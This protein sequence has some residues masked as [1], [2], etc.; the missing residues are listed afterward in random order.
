MSKK[1]NPS[2]HAK[3]KTIGRVALDP[4]CLVINDHVVARDANI[5]PGRDERAFVGGLG[6]ADGVSADSMPV[7]TQP[8]GVLHEPMRTF[9]GCPVLRRWRRQ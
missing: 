7:P 9:S 8:A 5:G 2:R 3:A 4:A 1:S 6:E